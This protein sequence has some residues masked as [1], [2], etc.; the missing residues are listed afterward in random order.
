MTLKIAS[1]Q[2]AS[3]KPFWPSGTSG[4]L[5]SAIVSNT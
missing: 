4:A 1:Q 5:C 2:M 3:G